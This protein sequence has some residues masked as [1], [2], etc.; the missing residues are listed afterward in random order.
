MVLVELVNSGLYVNDK[1]FVQSIATNPINGLFIW[2]PLL[3]VANSSLLVHSGSLCLIFYLFYKH[4][5]SHLPGI[6]LNVL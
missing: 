1:G 3:S 6:V 5:T 4:R 2:F